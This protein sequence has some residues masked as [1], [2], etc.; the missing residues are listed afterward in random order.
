MTSD[1]T[2]LITGERAAALARAAGVEHDVYEKVRAGECTLLDSPMMIVARLPSSSSVGAC[3]V[4][5]KPVQISRLASGRA[6]QGWK[7]TRRPT[8]K[9]RTEWQ[10]GLSSLATPR[11]DSARGT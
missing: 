5:R 11:Q 4:G 10:S 3:D 2:I 7:S 1:R 8:Q 6:T 9:G